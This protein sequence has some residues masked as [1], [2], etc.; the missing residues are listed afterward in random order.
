VDAII[1]KK[2]LYAT[3]MMVNYFTQNNVINTHYRSKIPKHSCQIFVNRRKN[4]IKKKHRSQFLVK[5]E[6]V[7]KTYQSK[8]SSNFLKNNP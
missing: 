2:F 4:I 3:V 6:I 7:K 1:G 8:K 5:I